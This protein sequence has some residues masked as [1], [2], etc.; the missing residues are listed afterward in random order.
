MSSFCFR[1]L[2]SYVLSFSSLI[3]AYQADQIRVDASD[4]FTPFQR[5]R[6]AGFKSHCFVSRQF[7]RYVL[8][9]PPPPLLYITWVMGEGWEEVILIGWH[10]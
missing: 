4:Q 9:V 3:L 7:V 8:V 10:R 1:A 6:L 2:L 5:Q